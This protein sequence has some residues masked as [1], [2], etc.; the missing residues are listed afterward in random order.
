MLE[1][2][3][4]YL[5]SIL[6]IFSF[7]V[8]VFSSNVLYAMSALASGMI[9][10]S[11]LFFSLGAEFLGVV[12]IAVYTGAVMALYAFG[13]M[14]F[15]SSSEIKE[16][17]KN[18]KI[19]GFLSVGI[20]L[21]LVIAICIPRMILIDVAESSLESSVIENGAILSNANP[22]FISQSA[23][24]LQQIEG[25][26]QE[27]GMLLFTKYLIPFELCAI[28]LLIAMI[29]GIVVTKKKHINDLHSGGQI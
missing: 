14:F 13:M 23:Q 28:M 27:I 7:S 4:F 16:N 17:I 6:V 22:N 20:A 24:N 12:Q 10:I 3:S 5:F 8:V 18:A 21:L 26:I 1:I 2:I 9:F 19:I 15:D 25:N 11:G 29:A